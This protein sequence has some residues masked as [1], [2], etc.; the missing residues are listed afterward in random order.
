MKTLKIILFVVL[1]VF[2]IATIVIISFGKTDINFLFDLFK[3]M[4]LIQYFAIAGLILF[5]GVILLFLQLE[6]S[7]VKLIA[8]HEAEIN[9]Y[10]A[11]LYD[12]SE[13]V[14]TPAVAEQPLNENKPDSDDSAQDS[15]EPKNS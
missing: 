11:K 14:A 4:D 10:K 2:H 1:L 7:K 6:K 8:Q 5:I 13:S 15:T 3:Q 9:Q 12:K